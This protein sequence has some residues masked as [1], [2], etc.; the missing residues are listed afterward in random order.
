MPTQIQIPEEGEEEISTFKISSAS[1]S[2]LPLLTS[3]QRQV[4]YWLVIWPAKPRNT[5][6]F[7][8]HGPQTLSPSASQKFPQIQKI[9]IYKLQQTTSICILFRVDTYNAVVSTQD[10]LVEPQGMHRQSAWHEMKEGISI[11]SQG[12]ILSILRHTRK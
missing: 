4:L 6:Y 7:I 3:S 5:C 1:F 8:I 9:G 11:L 10:I 12:R 2:V